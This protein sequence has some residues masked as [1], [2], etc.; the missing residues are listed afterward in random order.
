M[1]LSN[2]EMPMRESTTWYLQPMGTRQGIL[3]NPHRF[4]IF[5]Q[6]HPTNRKPLLKSINIYKFFPIPF[7]YIILHMLC[8]QTT[9]S[10]MAKLEG[11]E[12]H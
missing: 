1:V 5:H 9:L 2:T 12:N 10:D 7:P 3:K 8:S 11:E 4:L 6:N